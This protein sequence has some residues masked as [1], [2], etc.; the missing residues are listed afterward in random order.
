M[1]AFIVADDAGLTSA[2]QLLI[3]KQVS[4]LRVGFRFADQRWEIGHAHSRR[5]SLAALYCDRCVPA[6]R[7]SMAAE[8]LSL[9]SSSRLR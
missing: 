6:S 3:R 4:E 8:R 7:A 2:A 9:V 5:A 1:P